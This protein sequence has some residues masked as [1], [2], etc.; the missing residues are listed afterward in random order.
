M[1]QNKTKKLIRFWESHRETII[2]K[3]AE[4]EI[5]RIKRRHNKHRA[6]ENR[7]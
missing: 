3:G 2:G 7:P 4:E 1:A 5:K 6:K